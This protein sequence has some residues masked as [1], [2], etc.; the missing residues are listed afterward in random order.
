[1]TELEGHKQQQASQQQL[2]H[3]CQAVLAADQAFEQ[4]MDSLG[5][6]R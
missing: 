5:S 3:D 6:G 4:V 2:I 1:V